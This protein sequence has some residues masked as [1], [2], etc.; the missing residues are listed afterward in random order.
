MTPIVLFS[1]QARSGKDTAAKVL[2]ARYN[3]AAVAFAD[4]IKR[5]MKLGFGLTDAQLWGDEKEME[6]H[7]NKVD[8]VALDEAFRQAVAPLDL[9]EEAE[10]DDDDF[11]YEWLT[12]LPSKVTP[13]LMMQTFGTECVREKLGP[14]FWADIGQMVATELLAG[15]KRYTPQGGVFDGARSEKAV[16]TDFVVFTDGR[17]RNELMLVK[18]LGGLCVRVVRPDAQL[19]LTALARAHAS[20]TEM[21]SIP[22]WWF[23]SVLKNTSTLSAFEDNVV[24]VLG[25]RLDTHWAPVPVGFG[26]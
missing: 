11:F 23:D 8:E 12:D 26:G 4:P 22:D 25:Q 19:G 16:N 14:D 7:H 20:E 2:C 21:N 15:G 5:F 9:D 3:G 1:G 17:F 6:F 13:R 10:Y 18:Q 24:S